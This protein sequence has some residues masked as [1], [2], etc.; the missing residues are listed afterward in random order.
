MPSRQAEEPVIERYRPSS[1]MTDEFVWEAVY[2]LLDGTSDFEALRAH[3]LHLLAGRRWRE[4]GE[5]IP[6]ELAQ[7]ERLAAIV[8]LLAPGLLR[9]VVSLCDTS[10]VLH[11]V[12]RSPLAIQILSCALASTS[13]Y[14]WRT[15]SRPDA[16]LAAGLVEVGDPGRYAHS[17]HGLPLA[18]PGI[19]L[20][21]E[22]H[23]DPNWPSWLGRPPTA[24]LLDAAVPSALGVEGL[25]TLAPV[26]HALIVAVHAWTHGPMARAGDLVDLTLMAWDTERAELLALARRW[27]LERLL[28]TTLGSADAVLFGGRRPRSMRVWARNVPDV[29]ERTV[30]E[31]HMGRWLAGFSAL[32]TR[33]GAVVLAKE[34]GKDLA[35][36]RRRNLGREAPSNANGARQRPGETIRPRQAARALR[37]PPRLRADGT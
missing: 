10:V 27:G 18:W 7:D 23:S 37:T 34:V 6:T 11:K 8:A 20:F 4:L 28:R 24:E 30:L 22:V 36:A 29:R 35:P 31:T 5:E 25:K 9:R 19:P 17:P 15:P 16:L 21:V 33:R 32:G 26:H 3:R 14:S 13:T 12:R 1:A 2:R